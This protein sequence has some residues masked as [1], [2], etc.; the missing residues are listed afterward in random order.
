VH[1]LLSPDGRTVRS[2]AASRRYDGN[3]SAIANLGIPASARATVAW[4]MRLDDDAVGDETTCFGWSAAVTPGVPAAALRDYAAAGP[5]HSVRCYDG[6]VVSSV[7]CAAKARSSL[8]GAKIAPGA[9]CRF[10]YDGAAGTIALSV[11]AR[12]YGVIWRDIAPGTIVYPAV[13]FYSSPN[14]VSIV[15]CDL[16]AGS[17]PDAA[18]VGAVAP[19]AGT[20]LRGLDLYA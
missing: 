19:R 17:L 16:L 10:V 18:W 15:G 3:R 4:S 12:D 1:T 14:T 6:S 9:L 20:A 13:Y 8:G 5:A 11:D 2:S 7:G